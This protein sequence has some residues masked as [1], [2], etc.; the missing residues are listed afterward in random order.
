MSYFWLEPASLYF[1]PPETADRFGMLALG[2]DLSTERLLTA[3]TQGI[4]P[5]YNPGEPI[6]WW[7]P[8]PRFVLFPHK[9]KVHKSMRPYFNRQHFRVTYDHDFPAVMTACATADRHGQQ[10]TWITEEM[11]H[12]YIGLHQL[13]FAHSVEVWEDDILVGGLYGIALGKVFFGESMFANVSNASKYGFITLVKDLEAAGFQ[14]IDCQQATHHLRS[15]GAESIPRTQF[16]QLLENLETSRWHAA[17]W[18]NGII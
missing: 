2:G 13:G 9:L 5:W 18:K 15:L 10:G 3:Y 7:H 1:P 8:D 6:L 14:L 12:A 4:F 17:H 11:K 16:I